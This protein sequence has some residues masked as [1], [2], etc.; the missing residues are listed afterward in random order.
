[1]GFEPRRSND[2][3]LV[4][5]VVGLVAFAAW[6]TIVNYEAAFPQASLDLKYSRDEIT[7]LAREFLETRGLSTD[8]F[9]N[10]T[11]FD[12]ND[13]ARLYLERELGLEQANRLMESEAPIWRWR[14]RWFRPPGQEECVV[15]LTP[16]GELAGFSHVIPEA[17][18]GARLTRD[19]AFALAEQFLR[20]QTGHEHRLIEEQLQERPNRHD[21][22]FTWERAGFRA[23]DATYRRTI[24]VQ[25]GEVGRYSEYLHIPEQWERDYAALRSSNELYASIATGLSLVLALAAVAVVVVS[26]RRRAIQWRPLVL[27]S[28]SAGVLSVVNQWNLLPFFVDAMPTSARLSDTLI[29]GI[30]QGMGAGV[31]YFFYVILG[32]APGEPLY[33]DSLPSRLSLGAAFGPRG[34]RTREFFRATLAGYGFAAA[35]LVFLVSFYL[36]GK[37][38]GVWSP[39]DVSYSNILST[40]VPWIFPLTIAV[41]A[42]MSEE[43][44]FR[45]FAIPLLKRYARLTWVAV[46]VPAFIWGFLHANYPQ[47]PG[48]IRGIEV[49]IIGVGAGFLMLRFGI[50][51]P[52]IW[53]YTIDAF[54]VSTIL[55]Q[56]GSLYFWASGILVSGAVL[57]PLAISL[58]HYRRNGGF[59][60]DPRLLNS[61]PTPAPEEPPPEDHAE[62]AA[63]P[64]QP[65]WP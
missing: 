28:G 53:H 3:W 6:F 19:E 65:L 21:Y 43:F 57:I 22:V 64:L 16:D 15:W 42:A 35:H 34:F 11:L 29:L 10:I 17:E 59:L 24:V 63:E 52:L 44:W 9:L 56:S 60:A 25:G 13:S 26:L 4:L 18:A 49:G 1:M 38:F 61:A 14:A 48:F 32:A 45:L 20:S 50:L 47:Q 51:A 27:I 31:A 33:R 55:F 46:A 54:L 7:S 37:R 2:K 8:G 58:F 62:H 23:K 39:Q 12:P 40:A 30:L 36:I 41:T 5:V